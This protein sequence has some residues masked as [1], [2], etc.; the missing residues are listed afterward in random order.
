MGPNNILFE[1]GNML[2]VYKPAGFLVHEDGFSEAETVNS[3]MG[4]YC[5]E[6]RGV[7]DALQLKD[8]EE[9]VRNGIVHRLDKDTS[10]VLLLAKRDEAYADLK[11]QFKNRSIQKTYR[12][13]TYGAPKTQ[14]GCID[15]PIG[16]S[17][18]DFRLRATGRGVRGAQREAQ[19]H[20]K[21]LGSSGE[22]G[23]MEL[24]P[25]TGRTHQIRV[26]AKHIHHPIIC[27]PLYA[28]KKKCGLG[29]ARLALHAHKIAFNNLSGTLVE[30]EA[31]LPDDFLAAERLLFDK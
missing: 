21:V 15:V 22:F 18:K 23:Y 24:C 2:A 25:K 1:D 29:F 10:G 14:E 20:Y 5:P 26:H 16:R 27:D 8:G 12:A 17:G 13:F 11:E 9:L 28:P 4:E 3:W 19:T 6:S 31:P 30:V 7:G